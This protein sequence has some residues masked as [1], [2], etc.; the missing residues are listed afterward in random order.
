[1]TDEKQKGAQS[2][3]CQ[4]RLL[5]PLGAG[6]SVPI[7]KIALEDLLS[8]ADEESVGFNPYDTAVLYER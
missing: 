4:E 7:P 2:G 8:G 1:M 6:K 3:T 5:V